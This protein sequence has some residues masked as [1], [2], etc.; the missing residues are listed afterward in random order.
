MGKEPMVVN[1]I[2]DAP[3]PVVTT[4][5]RRDALT[6][7]LKARERIEPV[8]VFDPQ[9]LAKG[10][11]AGLRWLIVRGC[12]DPLTAMIRATGL[13]SAPGSVAAAQRMAGSGRA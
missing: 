7:T 6:V 2:L 10:L 5:T 8:A 11:P 9:D 12:E 4:S 3:G 13:A 1:A